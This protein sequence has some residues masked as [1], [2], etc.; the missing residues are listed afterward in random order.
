MGLKFEG[1]CTE[2]EEDTQR[3]SS[4][5]D[6]RVPLHLLPNIELYTCGVTLHQSAKELLL[7]GAV[8]QT[9]KMLM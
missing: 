6:V 3:N 9:I 7:S 5:N 4:R 2:Q 8:S 1:H